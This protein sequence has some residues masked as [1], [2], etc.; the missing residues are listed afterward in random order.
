[1]TFI[2][3]LPDRGDVRSLA[4]QDH[5]ADMLEARG[6]AFRS[7]SQICESALR[8]ITGQSGHFIFQ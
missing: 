2:D 5:I 6:N 8:S 1:M 7:L 4:G 3:R